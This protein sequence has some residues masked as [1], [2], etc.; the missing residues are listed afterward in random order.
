MLNGKRYK[1][2]DEKTEFLLIASPHPLSKV[3]A[4][5]QLNVRYVNIAKST[6]ARTVGETFANRMA[7]DK[8]ITNA[9][10]FAVI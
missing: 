6:S 1:I 5:H 3:K 8:Y 4:D 2:H 10:T 7:M 9:S